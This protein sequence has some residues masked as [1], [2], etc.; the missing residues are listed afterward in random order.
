VEASLRL[1]LISALTFV[2]VLNSWVIMGFRI[3]GLNNL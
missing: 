3:V 2:S 1:G